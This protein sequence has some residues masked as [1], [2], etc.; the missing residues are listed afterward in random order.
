MGPN[1]PNYGT[2]VFIKHTDDILRSI[3]AA[4]WMT[5]E[6]DIP[7]KAVNF[8]DYDG[9]RVYSFTK[10]EFLGLDALPGNPAHDGL[11]AQG[12]NWQLEE[13]KAYVQKYGILDIGQNYITDDG[14]TR[15]YIEIGYPENLSVT[16]KFN[17]SVADGTVIEWGDG[18][19]ETVATAG[20]NEI[21]HTY[22][23][24]G[25]YVATMQAVSGC[26]LRLGTNTK[27]GT[28][29][30]AVGGL[31]GF[32]YQGASGR[33]SGRDALVGLEIGAGVTNIGAGAF[34][35]CT[36]LALI[37]I[38]TTCNVIRDIAF[39]GCAKL[40]A[41]VLPR[42]TESVGQ[43]GFSFDYE[44]KHAILPPTVT[45]VGTAAFKTCTQLQRMCI[46]EEVTA[47]TLNAFCGLHTAKEIVVPDTVAGTIG[48]TAFAH[49]YCLE[50]I[51]IPEG[52]TVIGTGA[53][54][55]CHNL[56]KCDL[57]EGL[58][59][60]SAQAFISCFGFKDFVIPSTVT[61]IGAFAF[62]YNDGTSIFRVKATTPPAL[63]P[64]AFTAI[65]AEDLLIYVP[66]STDHSVLEAYK[67]ATG[68]SSKAD[69]IVEE[70]G[71][72]TVEE[73]NEE[74]SDE[75]TEETTEEGGGE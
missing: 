34:A 68:W 32:F 10:A 57:P 70:E 66:Y 25:N 48:N 29:L 24:E 56:R 20:D 38:P 73:T 64:T 43:L 62:L 50:E 3:A 39:F 5:K 59:T 22:P 33:V 19:S 41:I 2:P 28:T 60:I 63:E 8:Y 54:A 40:Q 37:T 69:S 16:L 4:L 17:Q 21:S 47:I 53:F 74:T 6:T 55:Q 26:S 49:C 72:G 52:V 46:P 14:K 51:N 11:T 23:A 42:G 67:T 61:S 36:R 27:N 15:L 31:K 75:T 7:S 35:Y 45:T 65:R 30:V 71:D 18:T 44:M 12:W 9:K 58:T 13:A 1:R